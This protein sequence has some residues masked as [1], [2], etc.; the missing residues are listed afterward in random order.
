MDPNAGAYPPGQP[1]YPPQ[2]DPN[3][4]AYPPGQPG[5]PPQP[6]PNA[7]AY[8]PQPDPNAGAYPPG[9]P[10]YPPQPGYPAPVKKSKAG[11]IIGLVLALIIV[12]GGVAVA[13]VAMGS[14]NKTSPTVV[15][16]SGT[17]TPSKTGT[18]G[19]AKQPDRGDFKA[20]YEAPAS[21][22]YQELATTIKQVRFMEL[23]AE[24]LNESL[25]LP[26]DVKVAMAECG[27]PNAFYSADKKAI[28]ICY[29]M[30]EFAAQLLDSSDD[31]G[32]ALL[33]LFVH[34]LGHAVIDL[35]QLPVTGRE[36]DAADGAATVIMIAGDSPEIVV[37]A[38]KF[39]DSLSTRRVE[40]NFADEHSLDQQ[41]FYN[42]VC[43]LYGS[44]PT[45]YKNL[46]TNGTL[47]QAR[48]ERCPDEYKQLERSWDK[49]LEPYIKN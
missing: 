12:G 27:Q 25:A 35:Y 5:Y 1:G 38:A 32:N 41:R 34:E 11:L 23:L 40:L 48:A 10:G 24:W 8:Q 16:P 22:K 15:G 3:A 14:S 36:E 43:W 26:T 30:W 19:Q 37:S 49:L 6:D 18:G 29:E 31:I 7:G 4:G 17:A 20:V 39:F 28:V 46:V 2:P 21:A 42:M 45:K 47:P 33:F 9:Q 13:L 44:N